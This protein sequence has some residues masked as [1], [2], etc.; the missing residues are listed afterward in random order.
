MHIHFSFWLNYVQVVAIM[1]LQDNGN[2]AI[3]YETILFSQTII[4]FVQFQQYPSELFLLFNPRSDL[5][6]HLSS[7]CHDD[8]VSPLI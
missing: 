6:S 2:Q 8:I 5:G 4:Q 1:I 3:L 7:G